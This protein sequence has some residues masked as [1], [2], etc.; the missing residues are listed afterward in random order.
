[1]HVVD[2]PEGAPEQLGNQS[3]VDTTGGADGGIREDQ[4]G[5]EVEEDDRTHDK[6]VY[7][8]IAK[9]SDKYVY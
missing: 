5:D 8:E 4:V 9:T 2:A 1:M 6:R 3:K 7:G